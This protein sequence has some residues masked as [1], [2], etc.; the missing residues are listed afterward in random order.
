MHAHT[1]ALS[2]TEL[3]TE[4]TAPRLAPIDRYAGF[5][6]GVLRTAFRWTFGKVMMP[7]RVI[8]PRIPGYAFTHLCAM[9]FMQRLS[10]PRS[11]SHALSMR[12]S[13]NNA[14][15]FCFDAHRAAFMLEKPDPAALQAATRP[16]DDPALDPQTRAVLAYADEVVHQGQVSDPVFAELAAHLS[17]RQVVE[18]VWVAAFVTYLN[19]LSRPLRIQS[20]GFCAIVEARQRAKLT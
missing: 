17:E 11:L 14:C 2:A 16:L 6:L 13:R 18:V 7:M 4:P 1:P 15:S 12:V 8:F 3:Q 19:L 5:W 10:L 9:I 20:D